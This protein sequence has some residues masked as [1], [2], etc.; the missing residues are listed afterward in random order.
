M[1][2]S[3]NDT[4]DAVESKTIHA[5]TELPQAP[6]KVWRA[7]TEPALLA[8]WLMPND[9]RAEVGHRFTFKAPPIRDWDG[10]VRCEILEVEP[11]KRLR[12]SWRGGATGSELDSV[13]TWT[14][15]P[16]SSGGTRLT[17]EH[18]GF[19]PRNAMAFEI[20][21]KG[22]REKIVPALARIFDDVS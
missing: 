20:M 12:Y 18:A 3:T 13:V 2:M 16:T 8:R 10:T 22:W 21:G 5:E 15:T 1:T 19:L 14:L 4:N 11:E 6:A 9:I 17:L 7:L